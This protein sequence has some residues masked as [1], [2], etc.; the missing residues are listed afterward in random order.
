[1]LHFF[2]KKNVSLTVIPLFLIIESIIAHY[3]F[4]SPGF[5]ATLLIERPLNLLPVVE[6][7]TLAGEIKANKRRSSVAVL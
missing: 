3:H 4:E 5:L 6:F 1:V 7:E 2:S